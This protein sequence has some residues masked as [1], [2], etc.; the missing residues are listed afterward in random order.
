[1]TTRAVRIRARPAGRAARLVELVVGLVVLGDFVQRFFATTTMTIDELAYGWPLWVVAAYLVEA[2]RSV[3]LTGEAVVRAESV[4]VRLLGRE[5]T[6]P[7]DAILTIHRDWRFPTSNIF[8]LRLPRTSA[9][10]V[11]RLAFPDGLNPA[12]IRDPDDPLDDI[13]SD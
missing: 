13:E 1:M 5:A 9:V 7:R 11:I 6:V 2:G 8:Y 4:T 12:R 10:R 3:V